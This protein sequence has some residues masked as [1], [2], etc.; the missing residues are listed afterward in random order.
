MQAIY[1]GN[2]NL[3]EVS[4]LQNALNDSY[5]ND[6][7]VTVTLTNQAG[8]AVSGQAFPLTLNYVTDSNGV[9]RATLEDALALTEGAIY[10]AKITADAGGDLI[11]T[12]TIP[13]TARVRAT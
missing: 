2:D 9:Y 3:L 7:T 10:T 11:G 5:I 4:G 8:D 6:A 1:I 12:W 13:L